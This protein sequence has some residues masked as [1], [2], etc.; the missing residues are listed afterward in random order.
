MTTWNEVDDSEDF[1]ECD[2]CKKRSETREG[3]MIHM[4]R[5]HQDLAHSKKVESTTHHIS[6]A[7]KELD[8]ELHR[9]YFAG[10]GERIRAM[11]RAKARRN[12]HGG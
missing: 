2:V 4:G 3:I 12:E 11:E 8:K 9:Q 1:W 10:V 7:Q 6:P 5:K